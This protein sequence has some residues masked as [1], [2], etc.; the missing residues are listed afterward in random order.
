MNIEQALKRGAELKN[1]EIRIESASVVSN[2]LIL[3]LEN[4]SIIGDDISN[5]DELKDIPHNLLQKIEVIGFGGTIHIPETDV[6][7]SVDGLMQTLLSKISLAKMRSIVAKANGSARSEKK[8]KA[9]AI[10]GIAGGRKKV[11]LA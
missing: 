10:N 2:K 9:S 3:T 8:A 1:K 5:I 6:F 7:I 4:H 11:A